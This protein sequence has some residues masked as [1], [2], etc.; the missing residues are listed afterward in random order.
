MK[1]KKWIIVILPLSLKMLLSL[2][3]ELVHLVFQTL[4]LRLKRVRLLV[5]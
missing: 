3:V 2:I 1:V 4:A 5:L